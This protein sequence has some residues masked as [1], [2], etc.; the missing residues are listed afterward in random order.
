MYNM[1]F[2]GDELAGVFDWD[3]AGPGIP[4]DDVA[5]FAWN[6]AVL[7]PD[8]DAAEAAHV[9]RTRSRTLRRPR[10]AR[11]PRPHGHPHDRRRGPH[12]G[13]TGSGRPGDAAARRDRRTGATRAR[14]AVLAARL[15]ELHAAL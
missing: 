15:P 3:V 10:P 7:F 5:I 8:A 2:D 14:L 6:T 1:A 11:G 4:L 12:R 9:L 13:G